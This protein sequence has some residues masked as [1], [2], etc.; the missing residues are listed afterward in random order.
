MKTENKQLNFIKVFLEEMHKKFPQTSFRCIVANFGY[1]TPTYIIEEKPLSF[2]RQNEEFAELEYNFSA[3]FE[4]TFR[5]YE[6]M[7][8]SD[9]SVIQP[10]IDKLGETV[11]EIGRTKNIP[12]TKI[13]PEKL[14]LYDYSYSAI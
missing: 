2:F 11:F 7:F 1:S 9:D 6:I 3:K 10:F 13:K 4:A 5:G 8:I 12:Q 14:P